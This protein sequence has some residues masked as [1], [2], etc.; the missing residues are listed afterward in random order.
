MDRFSVESSLT[1]QFDKVFLR[2]FLPSL[3]KE[4]RGSKKRY[5]GLLASGAMHFTGMESA[6]SDWTRLAKDFQAEILAMVF[7][8][9]RVEERDPLEALVRDWNRR[10]HAGELDDR[11]EYRKGLSKDPEE[12]T[13]LGA[14]PRARRPD[15]RS[16]GRP[17]RSKRRIIRYVMTMEGPEPVQKPRVR[18]RTMRIMPRS[19]WRRSRI[20]CCGS[21]DG[22]QDG[23]A[24]FAA[25]E[26][27]LSGLG[28]QKAR[29]QRGFAF[30]NRRTFPKPMVPFYH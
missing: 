6:R 5:A 30:R 28:G 18:S 2:F 1:M 16:Q 26:Y 21:W 22:F 14:A 13:A 8:Q 10:L 24:G 4:E 19:S 12:Y 15:A 27:L 9:E 11:L 7:A 17:G 25:A 29:N 3:R 23:D 20:W